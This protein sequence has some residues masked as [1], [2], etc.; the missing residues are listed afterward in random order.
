MLRIKFYSLQVVIIVLFDLLFIGLFDEM[1]LASLVTWFLIL[2]NFLFFIISG[3]FAKLGIFF[4][5]LQKLSII[6]Y[7]TN[8][9]LETS[10]MLKL[11]AWLGFFWFYAYYYLLES[12]E[13]YLNP[14]YS[15]H[16][17]SLKSYQLSGGTSSGDIFNFVVTNISENGFYGVTENNNVS[18]GKVF[19]GVIN[20]LGEKYTLKGRVVKTKNSGFGVKVVINENWDKLYSKAKRLKTMDCI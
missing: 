18:I 7:V 3:Y 10:G 19:D 5:F 20:L 13:A 1:V 17:L 9:L 8:G 6:L 4:L 14:N 12:N 16:D 2:V 11:T 15:E